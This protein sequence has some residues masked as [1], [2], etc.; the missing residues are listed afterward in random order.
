MKIIQADYFFS[1]IVWSE[2]TTIYV[3]DFFAEW[4]RPCKTL[5][6]ILEELQSQYHEAIE[7]V[8]ID[9]DQC[10]DVVEQMN[11]MSVPTVAIFRSWNHIHTTTGVQP[12]R[13]RS[14]VVWW[15][16]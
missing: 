9:I 2:T 7:V 5:A 14:D 3:V 16:L 11:I 1:Q 15:L 10:P 4:C 6:P 12:L 8:S 13:Y